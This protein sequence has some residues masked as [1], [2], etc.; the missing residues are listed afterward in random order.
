MIAAMASNRV[1]GKNNELPRDYPQDLKHFK[2]LT[3]GQI[4][5]MGRKTY[6]SI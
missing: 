5:V 6:E 1:I 4:I 3:S 2:D